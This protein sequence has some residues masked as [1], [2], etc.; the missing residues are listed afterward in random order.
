MVVAPERSR[1]RFCS[2]A[3]R[4]PSAGARPPV[5]RVASP[6]AGAVLLHPVTAIRIATTTR[7]D[8]FTGIGSLGIARRLDGRPPDSSR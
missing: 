4:P 6:G 7:R 2:F 1:H 5:A 3:S 8:R